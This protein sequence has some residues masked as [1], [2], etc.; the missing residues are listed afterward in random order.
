MSGGHRYCEDE[1]RVTVSNDGGV[2]NTPNRDQFLMHFQGLGIRIIKIGQDKFWFPYKDVQRAA[3]VDDLHKVKKR[4]KPHHYTKMM[5]PDTSGRRQITNVIDESMMYAVMIRGRSEISDAICEWICEE[6]LPALRKTGTYSM[7]D[8][9]KLKRA[10][11]KLMKDR[12][13]MVEVDVDTVL[14]NMGI[15]HG[16]H[17]RGNGNKTKNDVNEKLLYW[18]KL[19]RDIRSHQF[20]RDEKIIDTRKECKHRGNN[21][22]YKN[23]VVY[24]V[25]KFQTFV[26]DNW[27]KYFTKKPIRYDDW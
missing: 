15:T 21:N 17:M 10:N 25:P 20:K 2:F 4:Y 11:R 16:R 5:I 7:A 22:G 9:K 26:I 3:D 12:Q 18:K 27:K 23:A 1:N 13:K 14:K 19:H 8:H 24:E 6:V